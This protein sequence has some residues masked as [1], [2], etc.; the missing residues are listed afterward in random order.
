MR[1]L[2]GVDAGACGAVLRF[3]RG[4]IGALRARGLDQFRHIAFEAG[5]G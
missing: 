1:G 3:R 4:K 5:A 2:G